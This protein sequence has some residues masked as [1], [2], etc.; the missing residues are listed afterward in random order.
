MWTEGKCI[1]CLHF[2]NHHQLFLSP[3]VC[4]CR[5]T[6]SGCSTRN[7]RSSSP[8]TTTERSSTFFSGRPAGSLPPLPPAAKHCGKSRQA[9]HILLS[10][11]LHCRNFA[12]FYRLEMR[13]WWVFLHGQVVHHDPCRGGAG[14]WNSLFRFKHLATGCYLAAEM[15]EVCVNSHNFQFQSATWCLL[16]ALD[17]LS[18]IQW[19][20]LTGESRLWGGD[21]WA[22]LLG[23]AT[24]LLSELVAL[25]LLPCSWSILC[26]SA[27]LSRWWTSLPLI[28]RY[29]HFIWWEGP[30]RKHQYVFLSTI[31]LLFTF[32]CS[33]AASL[34]LAKEIPLGG[35]IA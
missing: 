17:A 26:L 27:L 5:G 32:A 8:A 3:P 21:C 6:S 13:W 34:C 12:A 11:N 33:G 15:G 7:R 4:G 19:L 22:A 28:S 18:L 30:I 20:Y 23:N 25:L 9:L 31:H 2:K 14:Y 29:F 1:W 35:S 10:K 16:V 24:F